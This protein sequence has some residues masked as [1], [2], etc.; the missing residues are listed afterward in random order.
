MYAKGKQG[1]HNLDETL[2][3]IRR[4]ARQEARFNQEELRRFMI[5]EDVH[6]Q[7]AQRQ[8]QQQVR[9]SAA[10]ATKSVTSSACCTSDTPKATLPPWCEGQFAEPITNG[11]AGV[12]VCSGVERDVA[13]DVMDRV[14]QAAKSLYPQLLSELDKCTASSQSRQRCGGQEEGE[15]AD[16][17]IEELHESCA[18][19]VV[20]W[21]SSGMPLLLRCVRPATPGN[22]S[23]PPPVTVRGSV[24]S[25]RG[26]ASNDTGITPTTV[27]DEDVCV[28]LYEYDGLAGPRGPV[29][30]SAR[31]EGESCQSGSKAVIKGR[32]QER[33]KAQKPLISRNANKLRLHTVG[34][35]V[36]KSS[37]ISIANKIRREVLQRGSSCDE[38]KAGDVSNQRAVDPRVFFCGPQ[39]EEVVYARVVEPL[40][41]YFCDRCGTCVSR[42]MSTGLPDVCTTCGAALGDLPIFSRRTLSDVEREVS[43]VETNDSGCGLGSGC[44]ER[45]TKGS[46][47][48]EM[49]LAH[50]AACVA[51]ANRV[52]SPAGCCTMATQASAPS[53][54]KPLPPT[55]RGLY[56]LH[57]WDQVTSHS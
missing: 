5:R 42:H 46:V 54:L 17:E 45:G 32:L 18:D 41:A 56:F 24:T 11:A 39:E 44:A 53:G 2:A 9:A 49:E 43:F 27:F 35:A 20:Q 28:K 25:T 3:D 34:T 1:L 51:T 36:A 55:A 13:E 29:L 26:N 16:S 48:T 47:G 33:P 23:A 31:D 6:L 8:Q 10:T 22:V 12:I 19:T 52:G 14:S 30:L 57:L 37:A 7:N 21:N 15:E 38:G 4:N 40:T 50:S